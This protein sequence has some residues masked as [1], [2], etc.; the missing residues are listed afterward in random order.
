MT[1]T[2]GAC[3][4]PCRFCG[5]PT[6]KQFSLRVLGRYDADY[7]RCVACESLQAAS[8]FWLNET[9]SGLLPNLDQG[10]PRRALKSCSTVMLVA[11]IL[12][13]AQGS[14]VLDFGGGDG[15]VCRLLRDVG[16]DA[17]VY[18]KYSQNFY[19]DGHTGDPSR[20]YDIVCAIEVWEHLNEPA[21]TIELLFSK[22]P[23]LLVIS[24]GYYRGQGPDWAYLS[25]RGGGHVFFCSMRALSILAARH[26]YDLVVR[27]STAIFSRDRIPSWRRLAVSL[28]LSQ[29]GL[30]AGRIWMQMIRPHRDPAPPPDEREAAAAQFNVQRSISPEVGSQEQM[31]SAGRM[32]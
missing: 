8:P 13:V 28:S 3:L 1:G 5:S 9:Y 4:E 31:S 21:E 7:L 10:A 14:S 22:R 18:D 15:L 20:Y 24:T 12:S 29:I 6:T 30:L 16:F 19:A 17:F 32:V 23:R 27:D 2:N 26:G 11:K 25:P